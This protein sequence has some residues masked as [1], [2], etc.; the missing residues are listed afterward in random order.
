MKDDR[1]RRPVAAHYVE[2]LGRATY[3]F[4]ACEW[5]VAWSCE[6][7]QPGSLNRFRKNRST[8][9]DIADEFARLCRRMDPSNERTELRAIAATFRGLVPGRNSMAHGKP[10]SLDSGEQVLFGKEGP[11]DVAV[12]EKAADDIVACELRLSPI[13][14]GFLESYSPS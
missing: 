10:V 1:F 11:I 8:A 3:A 12:L 14:H 13:F 2:A 7:L 4:A 6:R 5:L 9:G